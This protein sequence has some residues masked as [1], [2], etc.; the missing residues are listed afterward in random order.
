M[1]S[2][3]KQSSNHKLY[4]VLGIIGRS[5]TSQEGPHKNS[6][7]A[8]F[9]IDTT[10][11]SVSHHQ[12]RVCGS[13]PTGKVTQLYTRENNEDDVITKHTHTAYQ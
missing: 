7:P 10:K 13:H 12:H 9:N 1:S 8:S 6:V 5:K 4:T 3:L 11:H 2:Q